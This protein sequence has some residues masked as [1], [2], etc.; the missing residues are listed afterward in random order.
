MVPI[1][2]SYVPYLPTLKTINTS[3]KGSQ[4]KTVIETK[5]KILTQENN[6]V[7][8]EKLNQENSIEDDSVLDI[9]SGK[10]KPIKKVSKFR[11]VNWH[12]TVCMA[13]TYL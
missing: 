1:T 2:Y 8:A 3:T 6:T 5:E 4:S 7:E 11:I 9:S 10:A 12:N 13:R